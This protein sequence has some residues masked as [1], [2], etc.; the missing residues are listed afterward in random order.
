MV[1]YGLLLIAIFQISTIHR[2]VLC[3]R[4]DYLLEDIRWTVNHGYLSLPNGY[5]LLLESKA[6]IGSQRAEKSIFDQANWVFGNEA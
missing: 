1:R 4:A 2:I 6:A 5:K 3:A